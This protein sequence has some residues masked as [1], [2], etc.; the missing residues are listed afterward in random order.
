MKWVWLS[1]STP[2]DHPA[3]YSHWILQEGEKT[4]EPRVIPACTHVFMDIML[5]DIIVVFG[6]VFVGVSCGGGVSL[7]TVRE[8]C[9][10]SFF[11]PSPLQ[12]TSIVL[13]MWCLCAFSDRLAILNLTRGSKTQ[14]D[15]ARMIW[16]NA[17]YSFV[18]KFLILFEPLQMNIVIVTILL[19]TLLKMQFTHILGLCGT[20]SKCKKAW[21][22]LRAKVSFFDHFKLYPHCTVR[23]L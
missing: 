6:S 8:T 19:T 2:G 12:S 21:P 1:H 7:R 5:N 11:K 23:F 4:H 10:K 17:E 18:K 15:V 9:C 22:S 13:G 20:K 16:R 3:S 14:T